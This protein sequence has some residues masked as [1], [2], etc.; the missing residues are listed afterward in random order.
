MFDPI[1][2]LTQD[3]LADKAA[4]ERALK[5]AYESLSAGLL[6]A[7]NTDPDTVM[8]PCGAYPCTAA[9]IVFDCKGH[10]TLGA[11]LARVVVETLM[12]A[13]RAG[14]PRAVWAVDT[15]VHDHADLFAIELAHQ[16]IAE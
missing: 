14:E 9:G 15:I 10:T 11:A 5:D 7:L 6:R 8:Q 4:N 12:D 3:Y 1:P 2:A 13:Y 16:F